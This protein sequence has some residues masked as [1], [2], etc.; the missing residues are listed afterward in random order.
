MHVGGCTHVH[1]HVCVHAKWCACTI[2]VRVCVHVLVGLGSSNW[3]VHMDSV[4]CIVR[5]GREFKGKVVH[6]KLLCLC[7]RDK[8]CRVFPSINKI[9]QYLG[10]TAKQILMYEVHHV[11]CT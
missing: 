7:M 5:L 9:S 11:E 6:D 4:F 3:A 2:C 8:A 1:I 10:R